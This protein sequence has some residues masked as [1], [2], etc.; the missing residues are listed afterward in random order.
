MSNLAV[1]ELVEERRESGT[2]VNGLFG[3]NAVPSYG[4]SVLGARRWKGRTRLTFFLFAVLGSWTLVVFAIY[5]L[6]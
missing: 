4:N 5:M 2:V 1:D 6:F 3:E